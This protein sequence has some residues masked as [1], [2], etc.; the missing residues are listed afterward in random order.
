MNF[1]SQL[2]L[3]SSAI[4]S[5]SPAD[6]EQ[7]FETPGTYSWIAPPK[8]RS[9]SVVAMGGGATPRVQTGAYPGGGGGGLAYG[10]NIQVTPGV[11]YTVVVGSG[12]QSQGSST[13][14]ISGINGGYSSFSNGSSTIIGYGGLLTGVGGSYDGDGGGSG[15]SAINN[16]CGGGGAGGYS[17]SGGNGGAGGSNSSGSNGLD[18]SGGAGGGGGGSW[19]QTY[20][21]TSSQPAR[22]SSG[23]GT[24]IFG[25]GT[26][27]IGGNGASGPTSVNNA[28][29]STG[30]SGGIFGDLNGGLYG[31]GG[32][33]GFL[34]FG[35]PTLFLAGGSGANG[36]VRIIWPGNVRAFPSINTQEI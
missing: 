18:G 29:P 7:V 1:I 2:M 5:A 36:A 10:N 9:V 34:R 4:I 14:S 13:T 3:M 35:S 22:S 25:Q 12:G 26:N 16:G 20:F 27:G 31:G 23:G 21:S 24:G 28:T 19:A 33:S 32:R 6:D 17:G 15:G 30:G 11:S 8:V